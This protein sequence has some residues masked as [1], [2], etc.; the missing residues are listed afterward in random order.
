MTAA[1]APQLKPSP[2]FWYVYVPGRWGVVNGKVAPLLQEFR[3]VRGVNAVDV[4]LDPTTGENVYLVDEAETM[5]RSKGRTVIPLDADGEPYIR[6]IAPGH[7]ASRWTQA[8]PGAG[9]TLQDLDGYSAFIERMQD[10][11]I[12]PQ[13][14]AHDIEL[15]CEKLRFDLQKNPPGTRRAVAVKAQLDAA[16]AALDKA[17]A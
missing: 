10:K 6:E 5:L 12:L 3:L 1:Q 17:A 7:W 8:V 15:V 11:G 16:E 9:H 13:P 2:P 14:T 4:K